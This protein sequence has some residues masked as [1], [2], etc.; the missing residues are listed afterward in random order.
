MQYDTIGYPL[1]R[2]QVEI[3]EGEHRPLKGD[4]ALNAKVG[5]LKAYKSGRV[6]LELKGGQFEVISGIQSKFRQRVFSFD[7]Q[8]LE[9][10]NLGA[11]G[12]SF[13]CIKDD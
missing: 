13:V 11:T 9:V 3:A 1:I 7:D 2:T 10:R 4:S 5:K 12:T 6:V 8:K